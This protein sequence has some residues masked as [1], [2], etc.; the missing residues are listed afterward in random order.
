MSAEPLKTQQEVAER[1]AVTTQT[2]ARWRKAEG[3]PYIK[4]GGVIRYRLNDVEQWIERRASGASQDD[5][6]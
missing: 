3:M 5:G 6:E 2:L 4:I 1:L